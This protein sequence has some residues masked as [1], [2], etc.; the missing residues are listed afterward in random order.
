MSREDIVAVAARLFAVYL[1]YTV[2]VT[3]SYALAAPTGSVI[4]KTYFICA[5]VFGS[6]A[7]AVLWFFPLTVARKLLPASKEPR[8]EGSLDGPTALSLAL[9][10]MGVWLMASV[11]RSLTF[12]ILAAVALPESSDNPGMSSS[13]MHLVA[14][15]VQFGIGA[16]LVFGS[17]GFRQLILRA[18]YGA[19]HA[20]A[21]LPADD[22]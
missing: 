6:V 3:F 13:H 4:L 18:R 20:P 8:T 17:R 21:Q 11:A 19:A 1:A 14:E 12:S 22:P 15:L 9:A 16:W 5:V 2:L 10:I 7:V